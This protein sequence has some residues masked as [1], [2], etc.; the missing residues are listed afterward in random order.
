MDIA[1]LTAISPLDGRYRS[2]VEALKSIVSEFGLVRYRVRAEVEWFLF[3]A[4]LPEIVE[5]PDVE[6]AQA[7]ALHAIWRDFDIADA[8]AIR[9]LEAKTTN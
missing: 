8:E 1:S 6:P 7:A 4:G 9:R 3:L 2:R 5:L